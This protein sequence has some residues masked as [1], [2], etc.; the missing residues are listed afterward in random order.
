MDEIFLEMDSR[1]IPVFEITALIDSG[2]ESMG[3]IRSGRN[4]F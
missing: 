3:A 1:N 2:R 4:I